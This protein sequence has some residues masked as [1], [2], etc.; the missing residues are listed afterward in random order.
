MISRLYVVEMPT[1]SPANP[2]DILVE[3]LPGSKDAPA[4]PGDGSY[5]EW[6]GRPLRVPVHS[7]GSP[8]TAAAIAAGFTP[9]LRLGFHV[10]ITPYVGALAVDIPGVQLSVS[11]AGDLSSTDAGPS[12]P[13]PALADPAGE[14][15]IRLTGG[16]TTAGL[17]YLVALMCPEGKDEDRSSEGQ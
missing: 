7:G 9:R 16:V 4:L 11:L 14:P 3:S 1:E 17:F 12:M 5:Y 10:T 15:V 8:A 2:L 6:R 13:I